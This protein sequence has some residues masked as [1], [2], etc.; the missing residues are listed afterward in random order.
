[1]VRSKL[2]FGVAF[3]GDGDRCL[4]VDRSGKEVDG[5]EI[6]ALLAEYLELSK[7][8][9]TVAANQG[10][11]DWAAKRGVEVVVTDVGDQ[12]VA[13]A[14]REKGI[15]LGGEQSGHVI[16]PG[17]SA[18]DGMLTALAVCKALGKRDLAEAVPMKKLPQIETE[19]EATAEQKAKLTAELSEQLM[20]EAKEQGFRLLVRPSGTQDLIRIV[21]WGPEEETIRTFAGEVAEK[22]RGL[23]N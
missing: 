17:M 19:I 13:A 22:L 14:M 10:L 20:A 1:M 16:L 12:N 7:I 21:V 4:M 23:L 3:D 6:L 5:D 11:F 18:G 2:D 9:V 15:L 8:V